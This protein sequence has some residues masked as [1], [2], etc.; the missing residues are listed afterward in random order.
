[1][2]CV[3]LR[4]GARQLDARVTPHMFAWA[5]EPVVRDTPTVALQVFE[6]IQSVKVIDW[7]AGDSLWLGQAQID[8]HA[9]TTVFVDL[10][11]SPERDATTRR[12]K[13]KLKLVASDE[14]LSLARDL[15]ALVLI[16]VCPKYAVP[17][18]R[19]AVACRCTIRPTRKRPPHCSA[20]ARSFDHGS[21]PRS[22]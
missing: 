12:T 5:L 22:R 10:L 15:D 1:M 16:I 18:A 21:H 11:A 4:A 2:S 20:E 7:Y 17:S 6:R 3:T 8:R 19:R 9:A 14:R 13:V